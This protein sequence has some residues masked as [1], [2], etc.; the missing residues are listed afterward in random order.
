MM[1]QMRPFRELVSGV[2]DGVEFKKIIKEKKKVSS[3]SDFCYEIYTGQEYA[4][5]TNYQQLFK[6]TTHTLMETKGL[7]KFLYY[8][9]WHAYF[10][11]FCWDIANIGLSDVLK[12]AFGGVEKMLLRKNFPQNVH[13]L[14]ICAEE[15][16]RDLLSDE[17]VNDGIIKLLNSIATRSST[18]HLWL[19]AFVRPVF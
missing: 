1:H 2:C 11:V 13:A 4:V 5:F 12:S 14:R 9:W 15:V 19:D 7:G 18:S 6:I 10:D 8:S 3:I 17:S 16:L